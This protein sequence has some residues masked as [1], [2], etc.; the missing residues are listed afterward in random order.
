MFSRAVRVYLP[1]PLLIAQSSTKTHKQPRGCRGAA[2]PKAAAVGKGT[3]DRRLAAVGAE[4]HPTAVQCGLCAG[5]CRSWFPA[6]FVFF[7]G[8]HAP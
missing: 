4:R 5:G 8:M 2:A 3:W 7:S 6:D 1:V